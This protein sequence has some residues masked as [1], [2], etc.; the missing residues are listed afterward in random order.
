MSLI[1]LTDVQVTMEPN[2]IL[3]DLGI[4]LPVLNIYPYGSFVY[5]TNTEISDRDYVIVLKSLRLPSGG[6][7]SNAISSKVSNIQGILY[8]YSGF[9]NAIDTYD[10]TALESIFLPDDKIIQKTKDFPIR[11]WNEKE[12]INNII[13]KASNSF[14]IAEQQSKNDQKLQSKK[15][16]F[17]SIR[18]LMFGLQLKR[19]LKITDYSEANEIKNKIK[20]INDSDFDTRDFIHLRDSLIKDLR[21][22]EYFQN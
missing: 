9:I 10:M 19:N 1:P 3:S 20:L 13:K 18:I 2:K 17:H 11:K 21:G 4:N 16:I 14:Y 22:L 6:F 7:K 5:G 8:S 12:M 15:G